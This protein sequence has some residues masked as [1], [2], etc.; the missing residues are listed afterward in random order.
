MFRATL[1]V[2]K[3][4]GLPTCLGVHI[5][6][7]PALLRSFGRQLAGL[8]GSITFKPAVAIGLPVDLRFVLVL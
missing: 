2:Q 5:S 1:Q 4:A 3:I 6:R 8:L 7:V